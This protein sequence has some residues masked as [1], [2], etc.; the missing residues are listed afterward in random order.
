MQRRFIALLVVALGA[1]A[2]PATSFASGSVPTTTAPTRDSFTRAGLRGVQT[3]AATSSDT[4]VLIAEEP[5]NVGKALFSG[6]YRLGNPNLPAAN[7]AEKKM[8]LVTL[9]RTLPAAERAKV[10]PAALSPRLTDHEMN[11]LEYYLGMRFGKFISIAPSWAKTEPPPKVA[12][13]R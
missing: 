12:L 4:K 7:V 1:A 8:R 13:A 6:N 11:A 3:S 2:I 9:R 5:Y 10:D